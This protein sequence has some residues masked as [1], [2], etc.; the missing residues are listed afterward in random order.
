MEVDSMNIDENEIHSPNLKYKSFDLETYALNYKGRNRLNRLIFIANNCDQLS[1]QAYKLILK[2]IKEDTYD[3]NNY[4]RYQEKYQSLT[5]D[6]SVD[7]EWTEKVKAKVREEQKSIDSQ[8]TPTNDIDAKR[9]NVRILNKLQ[10]DLCYKCGNIKEAQKYYSKNKDFCNTSQQV[11]ETYIDLLKT[12]SEQLDDMN[13]KFCITKIESKTSELKKNAKLR[14]TMKCYYGLYLVRQRN[15]KSA[16]RIFTEMD[17]DIND[18]DPE[19]I[20][21]NDIAIYGGLCALTSFDRTEL[22][23]KVIE[24]TKFKTYLELEPQILD[25]IN[26]F[27]NSKYITMLEIL[28][29]IKPSLLLDINL[30]SNVESIY[31]IINEKAIVQYF[32]PFQTVDMNKMAK[33]FNMSVATLQEKLVKLIASNDIKARIDSHNKILYAKRADQRNNLFRKTLMMGEENKQIIEDLLIRMK[34]EEKNMVVSKKGEKGIK[35]PG[36]FLPLH[37]SNIY[38]EK[39]Y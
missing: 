27:Y 28:D 25:L 4:M 13:V 33:S 5:N 26:A 9:E 22:K 10:G 11:I 6:L 19:I 37:P 34:M 21:P 1:V 32:S 39:I 14:N 17:I 12:Y 38:E 35:E 30:K 2:Y 8:V 36:V 23:R 31:K 3:V 20:S 18:F 15:C 16:A 24:N 7:I 29:N